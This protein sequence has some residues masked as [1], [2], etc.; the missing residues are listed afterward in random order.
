LTGREHAKDCADSSR[1]RVLLK[2]LHLAGGRLPLTCRAATRNE[3]MRPQ[4]GVLRKAS[5]RKSGFI[6][7]TAATKTVN[8]MPGEMML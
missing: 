2:K 7:S 8:A 6:S 5:Q 1:L 4:T 3:I